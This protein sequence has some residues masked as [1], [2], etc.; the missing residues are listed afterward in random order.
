LSSQNLAVYICQK[1]GWSDFHES[2]KCTRCQGEIKRTVVPG[3]GKIV[4][5]TAIRYPPEGYEDRA[6]YVVAIIRLDNGVKVIGRVMSPV[7]QVKIGSGVM[8]ASE[9]AET[10]EFLCT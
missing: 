1:C 4:T 8:L 5:F 7:D 3:V 9:K 2:V 10:L 6:P